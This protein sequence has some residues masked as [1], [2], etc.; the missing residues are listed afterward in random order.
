[1]RKALDMTGNRFGRLYVLERVEHSPNDTAAYWRCRCDCGQETVVR[2]TSLRSGVTKSCG[3]G[4]REGK[5]VQWIE[6]GDQ[7]LTFREA[8]S[9]S[10]I[11]ERTLR[12]RY[13]TGIRGKM[14]FSKPRYKRA[15]STAIPP[16]AVSPAARR[17]A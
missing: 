2:G 5:P 3:C 9:A 1:M 13:S 14:L 11:N 7:C 16:V 12:Q 8:A 17:Q 10:G 15:M 4:R 6:Y